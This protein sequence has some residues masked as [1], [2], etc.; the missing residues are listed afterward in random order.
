MEQE[1]ELENLDAIKAKNL[2]KKRESNTNWYQ[3]IME[4]EVQ[5]KELFQRM[6]ESRKGEW[7]RAEEEANEMFTEN[8]AKVLVENNLNW[9]RVVKQEESREE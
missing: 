7:S 1:L 8:L 3:V 6:V 2:L 4:N 5:K 9:R